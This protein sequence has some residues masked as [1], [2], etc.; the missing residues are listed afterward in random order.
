M[1]RRR[2]GVDLL[3]KMR[4]RRLLSPCYYWLGREGTQPD[5]R[6]LYATEITQESG[7]TLASCSTLVRHAAR[8]V[9]HAQALNDGTTYT[10]LGQSTSAPLCRSGHGQAP[11]REAGRRR[12]LARCIEIF[13]KRRRGGPLAALGR[14]HDGLHVGGQRLLSVSKGPARVISARIAS[15][16]SRRPPNV[17]RR[18][19]ICA[20]VT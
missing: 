4:A 6:H 7:A 19:A 12:Q 3:S 15:G 8:A 18:S 17:R 2:L 13:R 11:K 10:G 9:E 14:R 5:R 20:S 1:S 16:F